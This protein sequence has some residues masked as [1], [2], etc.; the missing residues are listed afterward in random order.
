MESVGAPDLLVEIREADRVV[1]RGHYI[2]DEDM[3]AWLLS[4]GKANELPSPKCVWGRDH[5]SRR[6]GEQR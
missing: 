6:E 1:R 3:R 4:W 5:E 2:K